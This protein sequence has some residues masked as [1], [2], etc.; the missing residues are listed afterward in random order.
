MSILNYNRY[1]RFECFHIKEKSNNKFKT[2]KCKCDRNYSTFQLD[3][4]I[5]CCCKCELEK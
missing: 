5:I 4:G 2:L 1:E 3:N